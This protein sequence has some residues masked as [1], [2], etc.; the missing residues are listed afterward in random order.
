MP[1]EEPGGHGGRGRAGK[2][3]SLQAPALGLAEQSSMNRLAPSASPSSAA[4][5]LVS[6]LPL[7]LS[8]SPLPICLSSLSPAFSPPSFETPPS[9]P[10][11][12]PPWLNLFLTLSCEESLPT[13]GGGLLPPTS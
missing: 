6:L 7:S 9:H 8:S 13:K 12:S 4:G 1:G 2:G 10:S 11:V 3:H 5:V